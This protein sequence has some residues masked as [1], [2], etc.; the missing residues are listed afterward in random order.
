MGRYIPQQNLENL[1]K[2]AYK[3]VDKSLLSGYVL[4][5][6]WTWFVTLWPLNIAPNTITL[7]GLSIIFLNFFTL[8]YYD[9][10]YLTEKDGSPDQGPPQWIYFTWGFS[11]FAYQTLDAI[12]GKQARRTGMAGPLGELFDHGCDALNTTLEVILASR[13]LGLGRSWWTVA[14]QIATLANFYLTT[15]EEYHTGQLYLGYFSGPVEGIL[16]IVAIYIISGFYGPGF[17]EQGIWTFT[18]LNHVP[19]ISRLPDLPLNESFMVFGALGLGFNIITSYMNVRRALSLKSKSSSAGHLTHSTTPPLLLLFPFLLTSI[20]QI[21]WL[22]HPKFNNSYIIDSAAFVPFLCAWG[23]QFAHMVGRMILAHVTKDKF[24]VWDWVWVWS[25]LGG[26][27]A[28]LPLFGMSPIIQRSQKHTT[29]FVWITLAVS[30]IAY[31][32]FV[33]LVIGDI[34]EYLGVACFR[35]QRRDA[36]GV[37]RDAKEQ[38]QGNGSIPSTPKGKKA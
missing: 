7:T 16:M 15:W 11:L 4:N 17:W 18:R 25:F 20:L 29:I 1:K 3:G 38:I 22:S 14:S 30:F 34:T 8:I 33:T 9:P 37:W 27:D 6:F 13:A 26:L 10:C 5:P 2:Y 23:L 24:P 31:A 35:V 36:N 21:L 32:R 28:N 12:D 19:L